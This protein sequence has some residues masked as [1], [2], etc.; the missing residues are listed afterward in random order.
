MWQTQSVLLV[1][2]KTVSISGDISDISK[3]APKTYIVGNIR[4]LCGAFSSPY[5]FGDLELC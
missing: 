5:S 3:E 1:P 4:E 2:E